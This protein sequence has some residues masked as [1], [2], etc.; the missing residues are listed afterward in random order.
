MTS[1]Y[2]AYALRAALARLY[3]RMGMH[4]PTRPLVRVPT[5]TH[6]HACT[7]RPI[8]NTYCF[9]T[10]TMVPWTRLKVMLYVHCLSCYFLRIWTGNLL[11]SNTLAKASWH[12]AKA[13][14]FRIYSDLLVE[15]SFVGKIWPRGNAHFIDGIQ[16]VANF[17][18]FLPKM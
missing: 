2:G 16:F 5:F 12:R 7:H 1:Q 9:S 8:C 10:T 11:W 15:E 18:I 6:A 3:A 4:T 14:Q 13:L 17:R